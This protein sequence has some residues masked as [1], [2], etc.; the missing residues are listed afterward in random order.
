MK[1][2]LG[3]LLLVFLASSVLISPSM[4]EERA[5]SYPW[6]MVGKSVHGFDKYQFNLDGAACIVVKP[7]TVAPGRPWIWRARFWAHEPQ[8]DTAMLKKGWHVVYCDVGVLYGCPKAVARWDAFYKIMTEK[9][10]LSKR[11]VL[12]GMSRG[13]L[14]IYN[15]AS[16]N[17]EKVGAIYGDAP[18]CDFK[19]WPAGFGDGIG[20]RGSWEECK[21]VYGIAS[22]A[23]A[24]KFNGNP[25]DNLSPI[26]AAKIPIIHV[27]GEA[28]KVVPAAENTAILAD[29]YRK[30]GRFIEVISKPDCGHHPH[31]LKDPAPLVEFIE[32]NRIR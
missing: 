17:P 23:E 22:D 10:G 30:L 5:I 12:E 8:L 18:V 11:P 9:L 14:I 27:V 20:S 24:R 1:N 3:S 13:G 29:R 21:K 19:S 31:S 16:K 7:D 26:A 25:I 15:W 6:K 28:D 2:A 4:A 32:K